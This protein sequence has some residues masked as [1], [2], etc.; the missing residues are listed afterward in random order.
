MS[1]L[2]LGR[3]YIGIDFSKEYCDLAKNR[4]HIHKQK[5]SLFKN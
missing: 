1:A 2:K 4:I 5:P 3:K